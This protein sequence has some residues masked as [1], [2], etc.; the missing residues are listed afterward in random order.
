MYAD[1]NGLNLKVVP[2]GSRW[3]VQRVT[4]GEKRHNIGLGGYPAVS[5]VEARELAAENQRLIRQGRVPLAEK[6]QT[7][8]ELKRPA[9]PTFA[10]AA[11]QVIEMRRPTWTNAKHASQW[12]NTSAT[13]AFPVIGQKPVNEV[14]TADV[15]GILLPSGPPSLRRP[16]GCVSAWKP[17]STGRWSKAGGR[18]T[19]QGRKVL[20]ALPRVSRLKDNHTALPHLR[21]AGSPAT[22][23]GVHIG[24][25][26]QAVFR[27][28]GADRL[29]VRR[30]PARYLGGDGFRESHLDRSRRTGEG[31]PEASGSPFPEMSGNPVPGRA[32]V[33]RQRRLDI[34]WDKRREAVIRHGVYGDAEEVGD[35]RRGPWVSKQFQEV[36]HGDQGG[37]RHVV[38][39]RGRVG[40]QLGE[41]DPGSLYPAHRP[42]RGPKA[43]DGGVGTV[44]CWQLWEPRSARCGRISH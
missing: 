13:Y 28:P 35:P 22:G 5:L 12:T 40:P 15:L 1:G 36:V 25:G 27:V 4:V 37:R 24:S 16:A 2:S 29:Q 20:R 9:I 8:E 42:Y 17:C 6:H 14:T 31:A 33:Q 44:R 34:S 43:V 23:Q 19:P 30:S 10:Q 18:T 11:E 41:R 38:A 7:V 32:V 21:G 39:Q 26:D 3:W